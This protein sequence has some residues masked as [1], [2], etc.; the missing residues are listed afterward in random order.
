MRRHNRLRLTVTQQAAPGPGLML[1]ALSPALACPVKHSQCSPTPHLDTAMGGL[2]GLEINPAA[3][4]DIITVKQ[5]II[6]I[7]GV[8]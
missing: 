1:H 6:L 8:N 7:K 5:S 3:M 2:G 4:L